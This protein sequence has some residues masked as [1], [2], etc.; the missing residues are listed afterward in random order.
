MSQFGSG[1]LF[2]YTEERLASPVEQLRAAMVLA[3]TEDYWSAVWIWDEGLDSE[4]EE[5]IAWGAKGPWPDPEAKEI[6]G[7]LDLPEFFR[8]DSC[9]FI[10]I[11]DC[12]LGNQVAEAIER[13]V[14][15]EVRGPFSPGEVSFLLGY[16]QPFEYAYGERVYLARPFFSVCFSGYGNPS[17]GDEARER[18][19]AVSA[20]ER[21]KAEFEAIVGS[22]RGWVSWNV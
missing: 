1:R 17:E 18:I 3:G 13:E 8:E 9:L 15:E 11:G 16:H 22:L 12:P 19:L 6:P 4:R 5:R 14:P 7:L 21:V 10:L 2:F 20:V